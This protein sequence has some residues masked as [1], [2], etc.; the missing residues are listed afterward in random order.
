MQCTYFFCCCYPID[1][2]TG[3]SPASSN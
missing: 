2:C 3:F 1:V